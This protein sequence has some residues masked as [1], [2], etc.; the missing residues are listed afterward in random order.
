MWNHRHFD[1]ISQLKYG[2]VVKMQ[3]TRYSRKQRPQSLFG[4]MK[5]VSRS[6][7]T[8]KQGACRV[9][10]S[11]TCPKNQRVIPINLPFVRLKGNDSRDTWPCHLHDLPV[12][13]RNNNNNIGL[14]WITGV[15]RNWNWW[16]LGDL[17]SK[18]EKKLGLSAVEIYS[19]NYVICCMRM[20]R[21]VKKASIS[22]CP[23]YYVTEGK[24]SVQLH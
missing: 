5:I 13:N 2:T 17:W 19:F 8:E 7:I 4:M 20:E 11:C 3:S 21:P 9:S 1:R 23:A 18:K 6:S 10:S 14:H 24:F 16:K 22:V 12:A 15:N